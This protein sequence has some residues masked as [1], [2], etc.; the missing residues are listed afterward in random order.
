MAP[1]C[2]ICLDDVEDSSAARKC[3]FCGKHICGECAPQLTE[4]T[5][6]GEADETNGDLRCPNCRRSLAEGDLHQR[7]LTINH[8]LKDTDEQV[9]RDIVTMEDLIAR[10][11]QLCVSQAN[12]IEYYSVPADVVARTIAHDLQYARMLERLLQS[13][14]RARALRHALRKDPADRGGLTSLCN[15][16]VHQWVRRVS[17][18][19]CQDRYNNAHDPGLSDRREWSHACMTSS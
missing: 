6:E 5:H 13:A 8:H 11:L 17:Q 4:I 12:G 3:G 1:T 9:V 15:E 2:I 14:R 18:A 10:V 16:Y 7:R 19:T